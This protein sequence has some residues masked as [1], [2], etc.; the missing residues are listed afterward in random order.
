MVEKLYARIAESRP[1]RKVD[2]KIENI[3]TSF[4][5][6]R[7]TKNKIFAV[8]QV[9]RKIITKGWYTHIYLWI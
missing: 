9:S 2:N 7:S 4:R 5:R 6:N 3:V 8:R 1:R